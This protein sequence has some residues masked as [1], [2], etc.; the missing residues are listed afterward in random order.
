MEIWHKPRCSKR[1]RAVDLGR[2]RPAWVEV[3]SANPRLIERPV[4]IAG[5]GHAVMGR[6]PE[7]VVELV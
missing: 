1:R 7:R 5:G 6:P 2:D 3:M 4:V